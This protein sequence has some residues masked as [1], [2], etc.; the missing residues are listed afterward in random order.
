MLLILYSLIL[1]VSNTQIFAVNA[2]DD[3]EF[4]E[5]INVIVNCT[6]A[7]VYTSSAVM[8]NNVS[9]VHFPAGIDMD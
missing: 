8:S 7:N 4:M 5:T 6:T 9:L 3:S 1:A 2:S